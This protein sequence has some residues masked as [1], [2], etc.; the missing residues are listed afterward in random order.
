MAYSIVCKKKIGRIQLTRSK[1]PKTWLLKRNSLSHINILSELRLDLGDWFHHL[2]M[3]EVTYTKLLHKIIP[4][5]EKSHTVLRRAI[6]PRERLTIT[7][8]FLE[9]GRNYEGLKFS[10]AISPHALGV[11]IP[12]MCTATYEE[13][14]DEYCKV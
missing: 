10:A 3:D 1:W 8:W 6:T 7:L 11:I 14:K 2:G 12:E 5:I 13:L 9:T 4:C